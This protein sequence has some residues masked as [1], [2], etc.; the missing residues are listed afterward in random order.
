M[1]LYLGE[2]QIFGVATGDAAAQENLDAEIATQEPESVIVSKHRKLR[3]IGIIVWWLSILA[4]LAVMIRLPFAIHKGEYGFTP[5][6]AA[7]S[8]ADDAYIDTDDYRI[9]YFMFEGEFEDGRHWSDLQGF[10]LVK[11]H[12][13][14]YTVSK[15][16]YTYKVFTKDNYVVG[17][18]YTIKG[19]NGYYNLINKAAHYRAN[20]DGTSMIWDIPHELITAES[21][22]VSGVEYELQGGFFFITDEPV[23]FFKIGD[24]LYDVE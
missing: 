22:T 6:M 16:S 11:K 9:Y 4:L 7:G 13:W 12:F 3:L 2:T 5:G 20:E 15:D 10:R 18:L 17:K 1:A 14:G 8:Y 21:I 23:G 24:E 19:E